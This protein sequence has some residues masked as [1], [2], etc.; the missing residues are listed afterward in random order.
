LK[1]L[2]LISQ[3]KQPTDYTSQTS[4]CNKTDIT[5]STIKY[6][7][8]S[9]ALRCSCDKSFVICDLLLVI[10]DWFWFAMF[11]TH[12][13][14]LVNCKTRT[15]CCRILS[16][17]D[18]ELEYC[19]SPFMHVSTHGQTLGFFTILIPYDATT[20]STR[21]RAILVRSL[22]VLVRTRRPSLHESPIKRLSLPS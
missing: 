20:H 18:S 5:R 3:S 13:Q 8:V 19:S 10:C 9:G 7:A 16:R 1:T 22:P 6:Y 12:M 2:T 14:Y 15:V 21:V 17:A 4:A 11:I